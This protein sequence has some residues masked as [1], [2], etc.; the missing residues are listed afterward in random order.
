MKISS[1]DDFFFGREGIIRICKYFT[2]FP[3]M[4][5]W[6]GY[7]QI[8]SFLDSS[9]QA[10]LEAFISIHAN[11]IEPEVPEKL[12]EYLTVHLQQNPRKVLEMI[13]NISKTRFDVNLEKN[14]ETVNMSD[15]IESII[16]VMSKAER[17]TKLKVFHWT[18]E[19]FY[20]SNQKFAG[21]LLGELLTRDPTKEIGLDFNDESIVSETVEI[22]SLL[23]IKVTDEESLQLVLAIVALCISDL[24]EFSFETRKNIKSS[25]LNPIQ[26]LCASTESDSIR[27]LATDLVQLITTG[28]AFKPD[29]IERKKSENVKIT[30]KQESINPEIAQR[31]SKMTISDWSDHLT[32]PLLP[33]RAGAIRELTKSFKQGGL[34]KSQTENL[35]T[36]SYISIQNSDPFLFLSGIEALATLSLQDDEIMIDLIQIFKENKSPKLTLQIGEILARICSRMGDLAA[37]YSSIIVPVL[38]S[39]ASKSNIDELL[40]AS[41][42]SAAADLLPLLGFYIHDIQVRFSGDFIAKNRTSGFE[43]PTGSVSLFC[44]FQHEIANA[45]CGFISPMNPKPVRLAAC[46]LARLLIEKSKVSILSVL[47][48]TISQLYKTLKRYRDDFL[49]D[50]DIREKSALAIESIDDKVKSYLTPKIEMNKKITILPE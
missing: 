8:Q 41:S 47:D 48:E 35:K 43:V 42:I 15:K 9:L 6:T 2:G 21:Q 4:Q 24:A 16:R 40:I 32:D 31:M 11:S 3:Q 23:L 33:I 1:G 39:S 27:Q 45:V 12:R 29:T 7:D 38:L 19:N 36:A 30:K 46:L 44:Y 14:N 10:I 13:S 22:L 18:L 20:D 37:H 25:I 17:R 49:E 28:G 50:E 5:S 34:D 26:T